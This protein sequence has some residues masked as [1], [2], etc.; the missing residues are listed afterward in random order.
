MCWGLGVE[1]SQLL[2]SEMSHPSGVSAGWGQP[3]QPELLG[4]VGTS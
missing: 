4:D 2:L 1:A 3:E